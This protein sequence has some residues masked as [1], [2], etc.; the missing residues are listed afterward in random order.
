MRPNNREFIGCSTNDI[1]SAACSLVFIGF[2]HTV[3]T[4]NF[5]DI[6]TIYTKRHVLGSTTNLGTYIVNKCTVIEE[7]VAGRSDCRTLGIQHTEITQNFECSVI[8]DYTTLNGY[9][10]LLFN[11][12][13]SIFSQCQSSKDFYIRVVFEI[14]IRNGFNDRVNNGLCACFSKFDASVGYVSIFS[15]QYRY[16]TIDCRTL[17]NHCTTHIFI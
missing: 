9:Y 5:T 16:I 17:Y 3:F 6:I 14:Y 11:C 8:V 2:V 15:C 4:V 1:N 10:R 12:R 7:I 13:Y